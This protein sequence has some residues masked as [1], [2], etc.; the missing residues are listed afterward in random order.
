MQLQVKFLGQKRCLTLISLK[1][2]PEMFNVPDVALLSAW[3]LPL[4]HIFAKT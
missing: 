1:K 3:V 2:L 4:P